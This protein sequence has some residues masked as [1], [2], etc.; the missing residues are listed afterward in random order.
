MNF[1]L[2]LNWVL[3]WFRIEPADTIQFWCDI[4]KKLMFSFNEDE[5][6][7]TLLL[8]YCHNKL[9]FRRCKFFSQIFAINNFLFPCHQFFLDTWHVVPSNFIFNINPPKSPRRPKP[10]PHF[11]QKTFSFPFFPLLNIFNFRKVSIK[12]ENF[13]EI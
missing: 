7:W 9:R 5:N 6:F 8:F 13:T 3:N 2:Q 1:D 12:P 4:M 11:H 10:N